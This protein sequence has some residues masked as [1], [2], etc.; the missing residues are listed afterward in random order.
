MC[1]DSANEP[2]ENSCLC[3]EMSCVVWGNFGVVPIKI[4]LIL[5]RTGIPTAE[6]VVENLDGIELNNHYKKIRL[7][8]IA[9]LKVVYA[10]SD[11]KL[12]LRFVT[13]SATFISGNTIKVEYVSQHPRD[14]LPIAVTCFKILHLPMSVFI[15]LTAA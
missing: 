12:L 15:I 4:K 14:V 10:L 2:N 9:L 3:N 13:G 6:A 5:S 7:A 1:K 8:F 11:L